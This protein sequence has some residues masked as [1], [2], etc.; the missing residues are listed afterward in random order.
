[1]RITRATRLFFMLIK[2]DV[3]QSVIA[4]NLAKFLEYEDIQQLRLTCHVFSENNILTRYQAKANLER[5]LNQPRFLIS[6]CGDVIYTHKSV[7]ISTKN[8]RFTSCQTIILKGLN[9]PFYKIPIKL[10]QNE[11]VIEM[12]TNTYTVFLLTNLGRALQVSLEKNYDRSFILKE[13]SFPN[14]NPDERLTQLRGPQFISNQGNEF[15]GHTPE[16]LS[17][18]SLKITK[19]TATFE[20]GIWPSI[21]A[22]RLGGFHF[23]KS[24]P[25]IVSTAEN[26]IFY[27]G[28]HINDQFRT[29]PFPVFPHGIIKDFKFVNMTLFILN[30]DGILYSIDAGNQYQRCFDKLVKSIFASLSHVILLTEDEKIY[31]WGKND[32]GQ[33]GIGNTEDTRIFTEVPLSMKPGESIV[34]IECGYH[35]SAINT[36]LQR[37]LVS[38]E[39]LGGYRSTH[40]ENL[41]NQQYCISFKF[42]V[43]LLA[44]FATLAIPLV[45]YLSSLAAMLFFSQNII[46]LIV[47][48]TIITPY[49][50]Y[51][52]ADR[53]LLHPMFN[54]MSSIYVSLVE[55]LTA[56]TQEL[57]ISPN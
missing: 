4:S 14:M 51:L 21:S 5:Q 46:A 33:L 15:Y 50:W 3:P 6:E 11:R 23:F 30:T 18:S 7:Y 53:H 29:N 17:P 13:I 16:H 9:A 36:T 2:K 34:T 48:L 1:M 41:P 44:T 55:A 56:D 31:S 8:F 38:G 43:F 54:H 25:L 35:F 10:D 12:G 49:L 27:N 20:S 19:S 42:K 52:I 39:G 28:Y 40:F 26:N 47:E 37:L 24:P 22:R 57:H 32:K 45:I